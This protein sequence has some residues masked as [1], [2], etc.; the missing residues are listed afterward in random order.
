MSGRSQGPSISSISS[1]HSLSLSHPSLLISHPSS[2]HPSCI[3]SELTCALPRAPKANWV[4][5]RRN[6]SELRAGRDFSG[7][8]N[9]GAQTGSPSI[10][11][12]NRCPHLGNLHDQI[13]SRPNRARLRST[14]LHN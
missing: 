10:L 6:E 3:M 1:R 7:Y 2:I 9:L 4:S 8:L 13:L 14:K 11:T 12:V 5:L